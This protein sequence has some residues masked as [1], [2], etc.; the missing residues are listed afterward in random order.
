MKSKATSQEPQF[1]EFITDRID[2]KEI[3]QLDLNTETQEIQPKIQEIKQT[4]ERLKN[5]KRK[6][7]QLKK[8]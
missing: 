3:E 8:P 4:I 2:H 5:I 6:R 7:G 1:K